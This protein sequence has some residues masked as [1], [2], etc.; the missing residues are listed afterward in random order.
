MSNPPAGYYVDPTRPGTHRWWDGTAWAPLDALGATFSTLTALAEKT[1]VT[2]PAGY[3]EH[4]AHPGSVTW[5]N[6]STWAD[7]AVVPDPVREVA[8]DP[9]RYVAPDPAREAD[10]PHLVV[11]D[12]RDGEVVDVEFVRQ[13][14]VADEGTSPAGVYADPDDLDHLRWWDGRAW[15]RASVAASS[16]VLTIDARND[17]TAHVLATSAGAPEVQAVSGQVVPQRRRRVVR[18]ALILLVV[19]VAVAAVIGYV[20]TR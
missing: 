9:T 6:G 8:L 19:V 16:P 2:I 18:A 12:Q 14:H 7:V 5:W 10:L 4:P 3:Y 20:T 15:D 1:S 11:V 17:A 13:G